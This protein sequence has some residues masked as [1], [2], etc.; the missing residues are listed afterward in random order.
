MISRSL[1]KPAN[2]DTDMMLRNSMTNKPFYLTL[3]TD[4]IN[5]GLSLLFRI[6]FCIAAFIHLGCVA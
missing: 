5:T 6:S 1:Y 3:T 2:I 4:A